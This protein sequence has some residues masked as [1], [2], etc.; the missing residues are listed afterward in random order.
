MVDATMSNKT[1]QK[2]AVTW[3]PKTV[4]T[5][6]A[7]IVVYKGT[8][9]GYSKQVLLTL[10]VLQAPD[11]EILRAI[12]YGFVPDKLQGD[13][14]KTITFSQYCTMLKNMLSHYDSKLV[15][16]WEK[17]ASRALVTNDNIHWDEGMLATYYAACIMGMGQ[18]ANSDWH[19][20]NR[21]GDT[22]LAHKTIRPLYNFSRKEAAWAVLRMYESTFKQ[23]D[24]TVGSDKKSAEILTLADKRRNSIINSAT[25]I[26]KSDMFI[27]GKTYTGTVYYVSNSGNDSNN[28]QSPDT[29]WATISKVDSTD[30]K[31]GDAVFFERGDLWHDQ[32]WS[33]SGV[34]YSDTAQVQSP[35]S[36][37][38]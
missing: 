14:D 23:T 9:K 7:G 13:W 26:I 15:P 5:S 4:A 21:Y 6:K 32:L 29:A 10:K 24:K 38:L 27:Q 16:M 12:S 2:A 30:L 34:T 17:T 11:A 31:Y 37:A 33:Q 35:L 1:K 36:A 20:D 8:I 25:T 3:N 18:T 22:D 28:G 19:F